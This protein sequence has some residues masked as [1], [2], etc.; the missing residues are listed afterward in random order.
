MYKKQ[1]VKIIENIDWEAEQGTTNKK[2]HWK[3]RDI[4]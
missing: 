3:Y 4:Y 1:K 2:N